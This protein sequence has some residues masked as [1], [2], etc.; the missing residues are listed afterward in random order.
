MER[1]EGYYRLENRRCDRT[2]ARAV[3]AADDGSYL[4]CDYHA[5][6]AWA[7]SVA[8][9]HGDSDVRASAPAQLRT[10]VQSAA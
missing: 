10:G 2:G 4:V 1:C 6:Q 7:A 3:T 8:R 5:R 9:W